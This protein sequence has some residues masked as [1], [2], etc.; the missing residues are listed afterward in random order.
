[1]SSPCFACSSQAV[2]S[3]AAG[4]ELNRRMWNKEAR[5]LVHYPTTGESC[6]PILLHIDVEPHGC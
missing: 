4:A 5:S 3:R 2:L 6:L 1:M